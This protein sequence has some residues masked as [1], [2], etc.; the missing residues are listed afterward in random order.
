MKR[1]KLEKLFKKNGWYF[2]RHGANHEI[3]TDGEN[4]DK[5]PR[6]NEVKERLAN[7]LIRKWKLR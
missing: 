1:R 7:D 2:L 5:I 3:W 6:H 4:V